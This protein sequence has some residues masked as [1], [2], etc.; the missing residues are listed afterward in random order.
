MGTS[1]GDLET[2]AKFKPQAYLCLKLL[3]TIYEELKD[4]PQLL[5]L[6]PT[7]KRY[8]VLPDPALPYLRRTSV[9]RNLKTFNQAKITPNKFKPGFIICPVIKNKI[10]KLLPCIHVI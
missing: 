9:C 8:K 2:F 10:L 7:L 6:L 5:L 3:T 1:L 4:W